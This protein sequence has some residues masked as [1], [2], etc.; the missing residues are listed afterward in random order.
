MYFMEL[1]LDQ[2]TVDFAYTQINY[3][4]NLPKHIRGTAQELKGIRPVNLELEGACP[5]SLIKDQ[6]TV[7]KGKL[8]IPNLT[9]K[10]HFKEEKVHEITDCPH[11]SFL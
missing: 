9:Y 3:F 7:I 1:N 2:E 11:P 5:A 8:N 6:T 4:T 10:Q